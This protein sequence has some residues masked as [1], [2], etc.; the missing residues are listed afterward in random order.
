MRYSEKTTKGPWSGLFAQFWKTLAVTTSFWLFS[1]Y[2][3]KSMDLLQLEAARYYV[4]GVQ[5]ARLV[6][7]GGIAALLALMLLAAGF[8]L[9]HVGLG[10]LLHQWLQSWLGVGLALALLG[11]VYT[12]IPLLVLRRVCAQSTWMNISKADAIVARLTKNQ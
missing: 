11:L 1:K 2:R 10:M 12:L 7:L 8:I 6:F 5:S 3:S 9:L 4:Q